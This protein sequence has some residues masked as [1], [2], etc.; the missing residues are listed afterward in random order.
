MF[1]SKLQTNEIINIFENFQ[2][3][4]KNNVNISLDE[5]YNNIPHENNYIKYID[6]INNTKNTDIYILQ[7]N[8]KYINFYIDK[9][10]AN[11]YEIIIIIYY[12][13]YKNINS[14]YESLYNFIF[15]TPRNIEKGIDYG[16]TDVK[17]FSFYNNEEYINKTIMDLNTYELTLIEIIDDILKFLNILKKNNINTIDLDYSNLSE[18]F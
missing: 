10:L 12:L 18:L 5:K 11:Y 1:N 4:L 7:F 17:P 15:D 8:N 13:K 9:F 2:S 6:K 14:K 16:L 3:I